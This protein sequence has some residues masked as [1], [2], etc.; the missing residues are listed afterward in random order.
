[1]RLAGVRQGPCASVTLKI[2]TKASEKRGIDRLE[3][4]RTGSGQAL[5]LQVWGSPG[6]LL[7]TAAATPRQKAGSLKGQAR[8]GERLVITGFWHILL[9]LSHPPLGPHPHPQKEGSVHSSPTHSSFL[10]EVL[11]P[12]VFVVE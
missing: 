10:T 3:E 11:V 2:Q 1:M 7:A 9:Q 12:S 4:L 8:G 6:R 5:T